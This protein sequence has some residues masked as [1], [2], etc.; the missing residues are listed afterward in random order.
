MKKAVKK[1]ATGSKPTKSKGDH[2]VGKLIRRW[3]ESQ[4]LSQEQAA[5]I[6]G[7]TRSGLTQWENGRRAPVMN[8]TTL[9][10]LLRMLQES[11]KISVAVLPEGATLSEIESRVLEAVREEFRA[12]KAKQKSQ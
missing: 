9:P 8:E 7:V 10:G 6:F 1:S 3:R 2:P 12:A 5:L 4:G 11:G